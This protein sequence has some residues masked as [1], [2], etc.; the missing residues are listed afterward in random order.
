MLK[1][2]CH[3]KIVS[4]T[5]PSEFLASFITMIKHLYTVA[6]LTFLQF[7]HMDWPFQ[8]IPQV[9]S[10]VETQISFKNFDLVYWFCGSGVNILLEYKYTAISPLFRPNF[11]HA[12]S[13]L[14]YVSFQVR[15]VRTNTCFLSDMWSQSLH[16]FWT[17]ATQS[18][19]THL[20][21]S[22]SSNTYAHYWL[23]LLCWTG[24]WEYLIPATYILLP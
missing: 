21:I 16:I 18:I 24:E 6:P 20:V 3:F 8:I 14:S 9:L 13:F 2:F 11:G 12:S 22:S 15:R 17:A 5:K 1:V 19:K 10:G 23:V 7:S 4:L